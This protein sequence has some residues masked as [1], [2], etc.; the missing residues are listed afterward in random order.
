MK[1]WQSVTLFVL[2]VLTALS[3]SPTV[4]VIG[5]LLLFVP[6]LIL[7]FANTALYYF[8]TAVLAGGVARLA[9]LS[10]SLAVAVVIAGAIAVVATLPALVGRHL[11]AEFVAQ[12]T[13]Q[14]FSLPA[15]IKPRSF[16]LPVQWGGWGRTGE[17]DQS[18]EHGA[19]PYCGKLCQG[20]L[21]GKLADAVFVTISEDI[22]Q[23]ANGRW[24]HPERTWKFRAENIGNR[25][26]CPDVWGG[27]HLMFRDKPGEGTC[28][29]AE[30]VD[31]PD[32]DVVF[33]E[34]TNND[35][36]TKHSLG[37]PDTETSTPRRLSPWTLKSPLKTVQVG[38]RTTSGLRPSERRTEINGRVPPLPFYAWVPRGMDTRVS[39]ATMEIEVNHID[40]AEILNR[41]YG[42]ELPVEPPPVAPS[43][44]Q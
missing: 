2:T 37:N 22:E 8:G 10:S 9:G 3:W 5:L 25:D 42:I 17:R 21:Y 27:N 36:Y 34:I 30:R 40:P 41:R 43:W 38:E 19:R 12:E 39:I 26:A 23:A 24:I 1:R 6:G 16:E 14:D 13:A 35:E 15:A 11:F 29:V 31:R 33:G 4:L 28:L 44:K 18:G 20:L 32:A 7:L